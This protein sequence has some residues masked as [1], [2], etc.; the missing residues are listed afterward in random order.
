MLALSDVDEVGLRETAEQVR[1][2]RHQEVRV[3]KL[4]VR[5]RAAWKEYAASVAA[6]LGGV[7]VVV[8][9]AGVALHGDFEETSYEQF[10]WVMDVDFWGVVNGTRS[11]CPT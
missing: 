1:P 7:N 2:A 9:N 10:D 3:D 6:D 4:D 11:S 8:N 5:D